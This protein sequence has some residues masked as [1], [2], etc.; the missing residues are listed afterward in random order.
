MKTGKWIERIK[1]SGWTRTA[2]VAVAAA[3]VFSWLYTHGVSP[4]W[5]AVA[6][7]CF[8]GFFRFLYRVACFLVALAI[9]LCILS[10]LVF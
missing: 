5:T 10:F 1:G 9:I 3:I 4:V 7:V 8:R 2:M 6:I